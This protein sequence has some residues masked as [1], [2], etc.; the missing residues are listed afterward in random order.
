MGLRTARALRKLGYAGP[1]HRPD[2]DAMQV[3]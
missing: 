3:T 2:A 1:N